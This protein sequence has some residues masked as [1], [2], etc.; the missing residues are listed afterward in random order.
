MPLKQPPRQQQQSGEAGLLEEPLI[1][2]VGRGSNE[3]ARAMP[4]DGSAASRTVRCAGA[5]MAVSLSS[6]L[7][8]KHGLTLRHTVSMQCSAAHAVPRRGAAGRR[9]SSCAGGAGGS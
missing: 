6:N 9:P 7:Y 8:T 4:G 3:G 1:A 5:H 2:A